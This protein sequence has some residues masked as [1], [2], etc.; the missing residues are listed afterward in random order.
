MFKKE[1]PKPV[2]LSDCILL[3]QMGYD[4]VLR[5]GKVLAVLKRKKPLCTA[6]K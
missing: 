2:T 1:M 5:N 6:T 4:V 3:F